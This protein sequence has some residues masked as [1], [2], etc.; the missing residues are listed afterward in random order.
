MLTLKREY[1]AHDNLV[2]LAQIS[3]DEKGSELLH[4]ETIYE[5]E[6]LE[7]ISDTN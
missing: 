6:L 3:Y 5:Y 2:K 4:A 7:S 1:G